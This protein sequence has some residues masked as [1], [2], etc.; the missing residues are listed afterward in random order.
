MCLFIDG[1]VHSYSGGTFVD[2]RDR[3]A[4]VVRPDHAIDEFAVDSPIEW[5]KV[6][7]DGRT[8]LVY[9]NRGTRIWR[10]R[11]GPGI[12]TFLKAATSRDVLGAGFATV[13]GAIVTVVSNE[14]LLRGLADDDRE[15]FACTLESPHSFAPRSVIQLP[16]DRLALTGS[17]FSDP[18]D[19]VITVAVEALLQGSDAVQRAIRAKAPVRDRAVDVAVGPC[20]PTAAVVLRDPEDTELQEDE[21]NDDDDEAEGHERDSTSPACT[22]AS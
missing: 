13:D 2:A 11:D 22:C 15:I 8:V 9:T 12:D 18:L 5:L 1:R 19:V 21:D 6:S 3:T 20:A 10:W 14:G 16:G 4:K 17:F 7:P